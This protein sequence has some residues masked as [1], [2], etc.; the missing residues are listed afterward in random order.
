MNIDFVIPWVDGNDINWKT[1][2]SKYDNKDNIDNIDKSDN[3]YRDFENLHFWF[4]GVEQ[5]APWV[6]KIHFITWGHIP[7]WLNT[8]HPKINIV[9]HTDFIPNKYLPTFSAN[10]IEINLHR[11]SGLSENFVYFNDDIFLLKNVNKKDFFDNGLPCD[12]ACLDATPTTE[13]FSYILHNN[14]KIINDNFDKRDVIKTHKHKFFNIKYGKDLYR[15]I[16]LYPWKKFTGFYNPHLTLSF[17][18]QTFSNLWEKEYD[19]LDKTS[20]SKFRNAEDISVW[21]F[22]YWRLVKGEFTPRKISGRNF[23]IVKSEDTRDLIESIKKQKYKVICINDTVE[24]EHFD[25]IKDQINIAMNN[26]LS[27]KSSFEK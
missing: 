16:T 17:N 4:R 9:K 8:D 11:I 27:K 15:T 14:V 25:V 20:K 24:S 18:K 23:N 13:L 19:I 22:R 5:Y 6:N 7:E 12:I 26:I 2:K 1:E 10:P 21:L 3:R